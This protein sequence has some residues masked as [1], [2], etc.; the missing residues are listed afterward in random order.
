MRENHTLIFCS[1]HSVPLSVWRVSRNSCPRSLHHW[2]WGKRVAHGSKNP[3]FTIVCH[4]PRTSCWR[5]MNKKQSRNLV[6]LFYFTTQYFLI[7]SPSFREGRKRNFENFRV[8]RKRHE[9]RHFHI[10]LWLSM[11]RGRG[12]EIFPVE[13]IRRNGIYSGGIFK[14]DSRRWAYPFWPVR[15][16]GYKII[17]VCLKI[18]A[19]V[20]PGNWAQPIRQFRK[21]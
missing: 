5:N 4:Q 10:S 3:L 6:Q 13:E 15:T 12:R 8:Q 11:L 7:L 9:E 16:M 17:P 19:P 14:R 2:V 18:P 20:L 21:V 1:P